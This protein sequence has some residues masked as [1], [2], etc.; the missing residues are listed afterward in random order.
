MCYRGSMWHD[1]HFSGASQLGPLLTF[2]RPRATLVYRGELVP[3]NCHR[4][5]TPARTT[6]WP[7]STGTPVSC[8]ATPLIK[9][10]GL[11]GGAYESLAMSS[12]SGP[13]EP[14]A[15]FA[16]ASASALALSTAIPSAA[17]LAE[18]RALIPNDSELIWLAPLANA[19]SITGPT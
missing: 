3:M 11:G 15:A 2:H 18:S 8:E 4:P 16:I 12:M 13:S 9:I 19:A 17:R 6:S 1:S 14:P 10:I 5:L 7:A